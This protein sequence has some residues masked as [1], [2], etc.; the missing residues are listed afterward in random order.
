MQVAPR[1]RSPVH[2]T[3]QTAM[4]VAFLLAIAAC[5]H[6]GAASTTTSS[7]STTGTTVPATPTTA[8][9]CAHF[10][11]GLSFVGSLDGYALVDGCAAGGNLDASLDGGR[12]WHRLYRFAALGTGLPSN[13][14]A[15]A[16]KVEGA[17]ATSRNSVSITSDGGRSWRRLQAPGS[18]TDLFAADGSDWIVTVATCNLTN[19][20]EAIEQLSPAGLGEARRLPTSLPDVATG[21]GVWTVARTDDLWVSHDEGT[22]WTSIPFG[23][24]CGEPILAASSTEDLWMLCN[25]DMGSGAEAKSLY[26][27]HDGGSTWTLVAQAAGFDI[28]RTVG[29]L[30]VTGYALQLVA[31]SPATA[32][33]EF[34]YPPGGVQLST[35][36]G[37]T[38]HW[39]GGNRPTSGTPTAGIVCASPTACWSTSVNWVLR[40]SATLSTWSASEL[41]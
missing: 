35:D 34:G 11:R 28:S 29:S 27:S 14:V 39:V 6:P 5:S 20:P 32:L 40:S 13:A 33:M 8:A 37:A 23:F 2:R 10:V 7:P 38:W 16:T 3:A 1:S 15:F 17:V 21:P 19:C 30:T 41:S 31:L 25:D 4:A 12:T 36:G 9:A 18:I 26:R 22:S 24:R